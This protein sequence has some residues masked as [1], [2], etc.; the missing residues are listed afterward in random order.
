MTPGSS[1]LPCRIGVLISGRGS[2]LRALSEAASV[3]SFPGEIVLVLSNREKAAGLDF[4]RAQGIET[5]VIKP[6][7]FASRD[8]Y[9]AAVNARLE[10]GRIDIVCLAGF[11]RL[12]TASFVNHWKGRLLNIHPSLLPDYKGLNVHE[13]M[14]ADDVKRAGCSVHFVTEDMDGGPILGQRSVPVLQG[15]TADT[16]AARILVEEHRLYPA[17]LRHLIEG[18]CFLPE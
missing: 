18:N 7:H 5:D 9:D 4:A 10:Q 8:L 11:M 1:P 16:L 17:C 3:P 12:L 15:D 6:R 14:I 2:N 13:R